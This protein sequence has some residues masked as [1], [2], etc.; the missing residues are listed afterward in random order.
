MSIDVPRV[1]PTLF[2]PATKTNHV[3]SSNQLAAPAASALAH[4]AGY[5]LRGPVAAMH[6]RLPTASTSETIRFY[7]YR[8]PNCDYLHLWAIA[9]LSAQSTAVVAMTAGGGSSR[10]VSAYFPGSATGTA[11]I[12]LMA[13][14]DSSDS[15]YVEVVI[16]CTDVGLYDFVVSDVYRSSL[17]AGEICVV[18]IDATYTLAG[19]GEGQYIVESAT[20][21]VSGLI[22]QTAAAWAAGIRTSAVW[23]GPAVSVSDG[24]GWTNPFE[25]SV[26]R[27][28][29][30]Q[31]KTETSRDLRLYAYTKVDAGVTAQV[32]A[33]TSVAGD[34]VTSVDL[35]H[36]SYAWTGTPLTQIDAAADGTENITFSMNVSAGT[37]DIDCTQVCILEDS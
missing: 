20:A 3:G 37:G 13:A 15:G 1:M 24:D 27:H 11:A 19:L 36:T 18:P 31:K 7:T 25:D 17:D 28:I 6:Y 26:F 14:F 4:L 21:G 33:S 5:V 29:A 23:S 12:E 8:H 9:G 35:T 16:T 22:T 2:S 32:R 10:S 34:T 30:R